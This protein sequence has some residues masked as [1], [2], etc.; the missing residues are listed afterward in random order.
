VDVAGHQ[1]IGPHLDAVPVRLFG[2]HVAVDV[3][4]AILEDDRLAAIAPLGQV[5]RKSWN[6]DAS[7]R[8]IRG[9]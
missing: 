2:Q 6:H 7:E 5:M 3:M 8:A 9:D 1:A 4:I